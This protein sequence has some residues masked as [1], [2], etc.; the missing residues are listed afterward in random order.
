MNPNTPILVGVAQLQH[1]IK[2]LDDVIEPLDLML[3]ASKAAEEDTGVKLLSKVQSVRVVRGLWS[4]ENPARYLAD[5][6]GA[7]NAQTAITRFG[8]NYNQVVVNDTAASILSGELD[9]VLIT[10]AEIGYSLAKARKAGTRIE[11]REVPGQVDLLFGESQQSEHHEYEIAKGIQ[12]AI[13]VYPMYENAIRFHR[14]ESLQTHIERVSSLWSRFSEV[15]EGNPNAWIRN[16]VSAEKIRTISENNRAVSF[17]YTKLMNSNNSVDMAAALIMCSVEKAKQLSIPEHLWIYPHAGV[18]GRDH[19]C[20]SVRDNF[21][22]SPGIRLV[23]RRLF[24]LADVDANDLDYVDLYSCFPSAVQIAAKELGLSEGRDLTVTGGLTFGG[25]PLNNYV[26]HSIARMVEL[27]R[28]NPEGKGLITANGGNLY[29]HAH[30]IYSGLP[31]EKDF[32]R[33]D[34]QSQIDAL[35]ARECLPEFTG[36]VTIES[37][38]VMYSGDLPHIA[39]VSCLTQAGQ[40]VWVNSNDMNLMQSMICEEFCGRDAR[41]DRDQRITVLN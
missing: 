36:K 17:P 40:R 28:K 30:C 8:G 20:A 39:H 32:K 35:P 19:Y 3:Q 24:E 29:K 7:P 6:M 4:Y 1:R 21:Y 11:M 23:G 14:G 22:S 25:G 16:R 12:T 15:A 5:V 18:E 37:Y 41:I 13:Q 27:L 9:L 38:T 31:P 33:D 2:D 10:G 34:V 26:M